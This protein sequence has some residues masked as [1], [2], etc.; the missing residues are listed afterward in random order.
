MMGVM[1]TAMGAKAVMGVVQ[2]GVKRQKRTKR[3]KLKKLY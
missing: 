1:G 2:K 3:R